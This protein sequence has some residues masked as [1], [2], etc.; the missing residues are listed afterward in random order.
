MIYVSLN[1]FICVNILVVDICIY[2]NKS[3]LSTEASAKDFFLLTPPTYIRRKAEKTA[4]GEGSMASTVMKALENAQTLVMELA[5]EKPI[6]LAIVTGCVFVCVCICVCAC[7]RACAS[8][9]SRAS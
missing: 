7:V 1:V 5:E 4:S 3:W 8:R 9:T 6:V 2:V